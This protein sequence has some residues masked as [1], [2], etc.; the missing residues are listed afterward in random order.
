MAMRI[1]VWVSPI[2]MLE[3]SMA[4][5]GVISFWSGF[6]GMGWMLGFSRVGRV[7]VVGWLVAVMS[8]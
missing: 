2:F 5:T 1:P 4:T 6:R 8:V 3:T 7:G